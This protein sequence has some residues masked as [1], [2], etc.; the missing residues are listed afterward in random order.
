MFFL[1]HR[2]EWLGAYQ[3]VV[4]AEAEAGFFRGVEFEHRGAG[5][6]VEVFQVDPEFGELRGET[7][8][9]DQIF[10]VGGT[11]PLRRGEV[12]LSV[13]CVAQRY[14]NGSQYA[15]HRSR[16]RAVVCVGR[17]VVDEERG[18]DETVCAAY[19]P[20]QHVRAA[21]L[22]PVRVDGEHLP[23][24]RVVGQ[25]PVVA[26]GAGVQLPVTVLHYQSHPRAVGDCPVQRR[27]STFIEALPVD[28]ERRFG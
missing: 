12:G 17:D 21:H 11:S 25:H 18:P 9:I 23:E 8:I 3:A 6:Q 27:R 19:R 7:E 26:R 1:P 22:L 5:R 20:G 2:S 14:G 4:H 24:G 15:E 13:H 10:R 16:G 28:G